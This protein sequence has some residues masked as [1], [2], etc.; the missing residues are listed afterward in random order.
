[1]KGEGEMSV[2]TQKM[3]VPSNC[4]LKDCASRSLPRAEARCAHPAGY[5]SQIDIRDKFNAT[6]VA[7]SAAR[8]FDATGQA[9]ED[10]FFCKLRLR[11]AKQAAPHQTP[12][13]TPSTIFRKTAT[14]VHSDVKAPSIQKIAR[15]LLWFRFFV[16]LLGQA[17]RR[18]RR[19]SRCCFVNVRNLHPD[20]N[21]RMSRRVVN[22]VPDW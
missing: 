18:K 12:P 6:G 14:V 21:K 8:I 20:S 2:R 13:S 1:M 17:I 22:H 11:G 16:L 19:E 5:D 3:I 7:S 4:S 9:A 10:D 15:K